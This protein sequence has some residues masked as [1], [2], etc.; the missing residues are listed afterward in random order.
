MSTEITKK[1]FLLFTI[2][3]ISPYQLIQFVYFY[4]IYPSFNQ[5]LVHFPIYNTYLIHFYIVHN[6]ILSNFYFY[7]F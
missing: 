3:G 5:N 7:L 2:Y 1:N 6:L 4:I